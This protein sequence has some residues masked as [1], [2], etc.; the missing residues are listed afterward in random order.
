MRFFFSTIS[1][2]LFFA[3]GFLVAGLIL[4]FVLALTFIAK[5]NDVHI[6][7]NNLNQH[8]VLVLNL[9]RTDQDYCRFEVINGDYFRTG[10]S[11]FLRR[12][13]EIL[14]TL[15]TNF[16][17]AQ[18]SFV[19]LEMTSAAQLETIHA[20]TVEYN[21][22]FDSLKN[23]I[24]K[25][26]F[27]DFGLEGLMRQ[28]AHLL[29]HDSEIAL[30]DVL[31]LRRHEK[32][33][34]LRKDSAYVVLF[35]KLADK[36]IASGLSEKTKNNL[37]AYKLYF[38]QLAEL[39]NRIGNN[40]NEGFMA[41]FSAKG[42]DLAMA[43]DSL[44]NEAKSEADRI[45]FKAAFLFSAIAVVTTLLGL[46]LI[47][48][49]SIRLTRPILK[50]S[51]HINTTME[52]Q[53]LTEKDF[54][55][56]GINEIQNLSQSF[57][58][59]IKKVRQQMSEISEQSAQ[60]TE[61]NLELKKVNE[62]LD[63]F[64]YS[65]AHDLKSPLTSLDGLIRLAEREIDSAE[66]AEYFDRMHD[67]IQRLYDFIRDITDYARNKR[68]SL[69][70]EDIDIVTMIENIV[71][72]LRHLPNGER[73][74]LEILNTTEHLF[75][76]R[77]R[78]EIV[79]KNI[80][81]NA[82]HYMDSAK[83]YS[84]LKIKIEQRDDVHIVITDNGIGIRRESLP[85]I[86]DMF[87]RAVESSKGTGIGL[88]LVKEAMKSLGGHIT[89]KSIISQWTRFEIVLPVVEPLAAEMEETIVIEELV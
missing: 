4:V 1:R 89:V 23:N 47:Y 85:L 26:G 70:V 30:N 46:V 57:I 79:L 56:D 32:D 87:Y 59:L 33:F 67:S 12:R 80:I 18:E 31:M 62:E 66:H 81:A 17:R 77:T 51:S 49:T 41:D 3:F 29:E 11:K 73:I 2:Q 40:L 36:L 69:N 44:A 5:L 54:E 14:S 72:S 21:A 84:F 78:L 8:R 45:I 83:H 52:N 53:G 28:Q 19:L 61:Q 37:N 74:N 35:N 68:Q 43:M 88:Y 60:L 38:G 10:E 13:L 82:F 22:I 16:M 71:E 42:D 64:I 75:S 50:L 76:D 39:Q 34:L 27:R 86:F 6:V 20:R 9:I 65:A 63:K 15:E 55:T 58:R 48:I 25:R 24:D 7:Q